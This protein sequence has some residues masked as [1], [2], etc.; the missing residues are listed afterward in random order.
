MSMAA[1]LPA[2][3]ALLTGTRATTTVAAAATARSGRRISGP[4]RD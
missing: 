1:L 4:G 2:R 3:A